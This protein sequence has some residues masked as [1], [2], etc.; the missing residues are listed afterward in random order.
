MLPSWVF[1]WRYS[2]RGSLFT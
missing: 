1:V 2:C